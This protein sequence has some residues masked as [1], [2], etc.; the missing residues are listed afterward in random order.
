[1]VNALIID[2]K[3]TVAVA[4]EQLTKGN[5]ACFTLSDGSEK[6]ITLLDDVQIYHKFA[7]KEMAKGSP[8]VKYGEH[9]GIAGCD[10]NPG[11][12]VHVHNVESHREDLD[13]K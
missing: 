5:T 12:H 11:N 6:E 1:M 7:I 4:I 8:V 9:I 10:I 2:E 3:D 13:N